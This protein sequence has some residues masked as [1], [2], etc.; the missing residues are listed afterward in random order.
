MKPMFLFQNERKSSPSKYRVGR[1][2]LKY[3]NI[4]YLL[5]VFL[6]KVYEIVFKGL[7]HVLM[8]F[9]HLAACHVCSFH[10]A[11]ILIT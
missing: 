6:V 3:L 11:N 8:A 9:A 1:N 2:S 5:T 4:F 7:H 10:T